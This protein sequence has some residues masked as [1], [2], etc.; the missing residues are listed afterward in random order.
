MLTIPN[1]VFGTTLYQ[2]LTFQSVLG[3]KQFCQCRAFGDLGLTLKTWLN[4]CQC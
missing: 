3:G 4:P 1:H 2:L